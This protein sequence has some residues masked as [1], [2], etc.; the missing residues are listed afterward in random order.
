MRIP[1][2]DN[3]YEFPKPI[4]PQ[5]SIFGSA[6]KNKTRDETNWGLLWISKIRANKLDR[7]KNMEI[8][9]QIFIIFWIRFTSR[10]VY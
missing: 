1:E 2:R 3:L 9:N 5:I 6:S 10:I 4:G 8:L 7:E